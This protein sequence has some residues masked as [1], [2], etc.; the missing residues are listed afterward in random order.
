MG[1]PWSLAYSRIMGSITK[2]RKE[3]AD[4]KDDEKQF[5]K[6]TVQIRV[7]LLN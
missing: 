2:D 5:Q 4:R 3:M 6:G 1:Y 7:V